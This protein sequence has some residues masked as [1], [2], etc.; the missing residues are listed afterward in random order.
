MKQKETNVIDNNEWIATYLKGQDVDT[1]G[2]GS[3]VRYEKEFVGLDA[4]VMVRFPFAISFGLVLAR[5]IM[6]T[7]KDGPNVLYLHH[8]RQ[9]NY[10]LD[11]TAYLL[12]KEIEKRGYRAMPFPASQLVDW[13]N[14]KGH[15][16]HKR[17]GEISGVGWIGRNN[18]L[19]HPVYGARVRY[20]TVLTD[21]PLTAAAPL[22]RGCEACRACIN[23]CPAGAIKERASDF[24]HVGCFNMVTQ[25]KNKRNLG[26]HICGICI[27]ACMGER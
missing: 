14:Q 13:R 25:L 26:H 9:A 5:G 18:L 3:M 22:E 10:R 24:D 16:S 15:V 12:A 8:Y 27:E 19:I 17:V 7:V 4:S 20:N 21:M 23:A 1:F 6:E 11:M 2:V